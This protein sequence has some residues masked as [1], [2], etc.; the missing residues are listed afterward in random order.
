MDA[1]STGQSLVWAFGLDYMKE[2]MG[3]FTKSGGLVYVAHI[4]LISLRLCQCLGPRGVPAGLC[5][6]LA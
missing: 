4:D 6:A 3:D 1:G 2:R 5:F